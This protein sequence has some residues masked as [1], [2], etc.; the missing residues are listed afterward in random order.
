MKSCV[1]VL[2]TMDD[3][4]LLDKHNNFIAGEILGITNT[5]VPCGPVLFVWQTEMF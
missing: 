2:R 5:M 4:V 3:N 1:F